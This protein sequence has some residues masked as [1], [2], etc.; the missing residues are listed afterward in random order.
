MTSI[1]DYFKHDP[2]SNR[3]AI[4]E[5]YQLFDFYTTKYR[6]EV[7]AKRLDRM[8]KHVLI[9]ESETR[10]GAVFSIWYK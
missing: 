4:K 10:D 5:G 1:I 3:S 6:A 2:N 9:T 7:E 8:G